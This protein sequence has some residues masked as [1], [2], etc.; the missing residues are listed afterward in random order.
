[1]VAT[2]GCFDLLHTGHVHLLD[3]ARR[4]GDCLIVFVNS[5]DSVARLKGPT[6]PVVAQSDREAMLLALRSVDAVLVFDED[7][8]ERALRLLQPDIFVKGGDYSLTDLPEAAVVRSWGGHAVTVP[9]LAGRS[10]TT[11]IH[12][13]VRES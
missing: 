7:T 8:P 5:D 11:L 4:L 3:E 1:M 13:L 6:R 10:T 12:H 9:Y 2:G